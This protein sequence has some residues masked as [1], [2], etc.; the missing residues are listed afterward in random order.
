MNKV[1]KSVGESGLLTKLDLQEDLTLTLRDRSKYI[2]KI[3]EFNLHP[4]FS[5]INIKTSPI[6]ST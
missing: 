4:D 6:G 3:L 2:Q 1:S 5:I